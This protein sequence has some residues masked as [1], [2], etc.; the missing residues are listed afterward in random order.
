MSRYSRPPVW[1]APAF[2]ARPGIWL[3]LLALILL[4]F[5]VPIPMLLQRS[6]IISTLGDRAHVVLLGALTMALYWRGPL[7]GRLDLVVPLA[8]V[9]GGGIEI[10]QMFVGRAAL[11]HDFLLDLL[12]I[13]AAAGLIFWRGYGRRGGMVLM[14]VIMAVVV[15]ELRTLPGRQAAS[16]DLRERFPRLSAFDEVRP[17]TSWHGY[18]G[19][20]ISLADTPRGAALRLDA[21]PSRIWPGV[22]LRDFPHDWSAHD[23]LKMDL[24]LVRAA[25]DSVEVGVRMD[26]YRGRR[27]DEWIAWRLAVTRQW[28]TVALP[29]SNQST[30]WSHRPFE[31]DDVY[32]MAIFFMQPPDTA[33]LEIRRVHLQ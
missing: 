19:S 31:P 6:I 11:W 1:P 16:L 32:A 18:G 2:L 17:L 10:V 9:I 8:A 4:P 30:H 29:I 33:S 25:A 5:L 21:L 24:R 14:V 23:T 7:A 12:G 27:D 13:G 20:R 28:R 3:A 15:W 26:D 22:I